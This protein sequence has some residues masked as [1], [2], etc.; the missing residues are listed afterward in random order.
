LLNCVK[1]AIRIILFLAKNRSFA[2]QSHM[3]KIYL[4]VTLISAVLLLQNCKKDT[5]VA[6]ASST[7]IL[8]AQIN[9]TTWNPT[10]INAAINYNSAL[11]TKS[12]VCT[13]S[14]AT[15]Q[16]NF[17]VALATSS[18]TAGFPLNTY[19]V[20]T[21]GNVNMAYNIFSNGVYIPQGTV[22]VGSGSIIITAVD[23]VKKVITGTYSFTSVKNNYDGNGNI[24][25]TNIAEVSQGAF[26]SMPYTF[27]AN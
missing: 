8:F 7:A 22:G 15:Q 5:V 17:S 10:T 2:K 23:S 27:T 3:K 1:K 19:N 11:Q 24:I 16:V 20:N 4:I 21:T 6:T 13:G 9:D 12:F 14:T 25:S 18:N 26:N